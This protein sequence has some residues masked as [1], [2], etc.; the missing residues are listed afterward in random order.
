[1]DETPKIATV[2]DDEQMHVGEVFAQ[3]L[4]VSAEKA[5]KRDEICEQLRAVADDVLAA[6]PKFAAALASPR[7]SQ[8]EK[9]G[10]IDRV[11]EG[12]IDPLLLNFFKILCRRD[13]L[14]F[15]RSI[16]QAAM[17]IEDTAVGRLRVLVT[18]ATEL[19]DSQLEAIKASLKTK[20]SKEIAVRRRVDPSILGGLVV[21]V[22]DTVYDSS[23]STKI[24]TNRRATIASTEQ[25][26]R[27]KFSSL[28]NE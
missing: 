2:F 27:E 14:G 7:V 24:E 18:T 16:S 22:G 17:A 9:V 26:L 11:F 28:I 10:L 3:A 8:S 25:S 19:D 23:L 15:I 5:G 1:M 4:M 12:R 6:N 21:R 20:F 13:R